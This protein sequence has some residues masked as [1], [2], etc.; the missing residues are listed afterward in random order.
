MGKNIVNL[1]GTT[2]KAMTIDAKI[3]VHSPF[4]NI[5]GNLHLGQCCTRKRSASRPRDVIISLKS[6]K[7]GEENTNKDTRPR[8]FSVVP[9]DSTMRKNLNFTKLH[10]NIFGVLGFVHL[11][12][13][14]FLA[15]ECDQALAQIA[16][17]S[18]KVSTSGNSQHSTGNVPEKSASLDHPLRDGARLQTSTSASHLQ[19]F[20]FC[21]CHCFNLHYS[22]LPYLQLRW[23]LS[24]ELHTRCTW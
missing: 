20:L 13:C 22:S 12:P 7:P 5:L 16:M 11:F 6:V 14:Y 18:C 17:R 10:L 1:S 21:E 23:I 9:S 19:L 2:P 4:P 3:W 15:C 8:D 24:Y